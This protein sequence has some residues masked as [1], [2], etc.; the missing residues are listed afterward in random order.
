[1]SDPTAYNWASVLDQDDATLSDLATAVDELAIP[2]RA[3]REV[4][5]KIGDGEMGDP[6]QFVPNLAIALDRTD[7]QG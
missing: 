1:M 2:L 4:L 3:C 5:D 6:P 7:G